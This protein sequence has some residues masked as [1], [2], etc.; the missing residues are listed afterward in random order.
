MCT[1]IFPMDK[2]KNFRYCSL[3]SHNDVMVECFFEKDSLDLITLSANCTLCLWE[4]NID[5]DM[6][7]PQKRAPK[8][9]MRKIS[10]KEDDDEDDDIPI[11]NVEDQFENVNFTGD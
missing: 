5:L 9:K 2:F 8:K 1:K 11:N 6:L 7:E 4:C 3:A 10:E